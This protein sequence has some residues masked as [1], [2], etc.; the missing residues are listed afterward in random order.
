PDI[1]TYRWQPG[2][3]VT[4]DVLRTGPDW[5]RVLRE[6]RGPFEDHGWVSVEEAAAPAAHGLHRWHYRPDPPRLIE[7]AA[8]DRDGVGERG[9]RDNMHVSWVSGAPYAHAP[10]PHG[11]P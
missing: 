3:R 2:E 5:A 11:P 6:R 4:L 7:T 9:D 8:F 10:L 1:R